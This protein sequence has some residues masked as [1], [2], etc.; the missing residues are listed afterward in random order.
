M[1]LLHADVQT[2]VFARSRMG[3]ERLL[4]ELRE[5]AVRA[6]FSPDAIQ[7]YRGGY[8]P[9]ERRAIERDLR[10]GKTRVVVATNALE[11]GIDIGALDASVLVGYPGSIAAT[12][13]QMGRAG[14]RAGTSLSAL[15]ATPSPLDQ[16]LVSHP[17]YFFGRS[18]EEARVNPDT[19]SLLASHLTCAAFELPFEQRRRL[20]QSG[21]RPRA[22]G[23][24]ERGRHPPSQ[25]QPVHVGGRFVS[26]AGA[27]AAHRDAG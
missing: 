23:G 27:L 4:R 15:V 14:R 2:I 13:Q 20:R 1:R 19:L 16:Y 3:V 24:A 21:E 22:A 25:R 9:Q 8:L 26:G 5:R 6:G 12:R 18:P 7:G 17:E 10:N 11:L